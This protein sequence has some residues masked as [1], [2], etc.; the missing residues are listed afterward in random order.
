[1]RVLKNF[2]SVRDPLRPRSSYIEQVSMQSITS[3]CCCACIQTFKGL[4]P[5]PLIESVQFVIC[6]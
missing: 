2:K 5:Y 6:S 1:V 4:L 3:V